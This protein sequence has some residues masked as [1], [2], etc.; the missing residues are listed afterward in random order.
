MP[1]RMTMLECWM[2]PPG[3]LLLIKEVLTPIMAK[4]LNYMYCVYNN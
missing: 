4:E 1:G 2:K 3:T